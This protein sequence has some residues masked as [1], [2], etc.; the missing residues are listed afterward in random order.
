MRGIWD[1]HEAIQMMDVQFCRVPGRLGF[2]AAK[3][4]LPQDAEVVYRSA[5]PNS[6]V[7]PTAWFGKSADGQIYRYSPANDGTAHFSGID[8]VGDGVRNLTQYALDR[9][10]GL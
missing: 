5:V 2:S 10:K 1:T 7:N 9:M 4:A 6:P 3:T 8:G